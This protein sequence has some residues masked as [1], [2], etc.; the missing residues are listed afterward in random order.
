MS[1]F[2]ISEEE[3]REINDKV[4]AKFDSWVLND[5]YLILEVMQEI[6]YRI[7]KE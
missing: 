2:L 1:D 6:G 7:V 4:F 5:I 3:I